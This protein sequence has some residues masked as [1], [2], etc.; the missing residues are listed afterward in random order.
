ME[1][2]IE[3]LKMVSPRE[4]NKLHADVLILNKEQVAHQ[5]KI[6]EI[7]PEDIYSIIS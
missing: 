2:S 4:G 7:R 3:N 1:T 5:S 6:A